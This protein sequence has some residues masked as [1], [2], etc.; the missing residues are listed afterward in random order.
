MSKIKMPRKSPSLDMTPMVDLAFLLVTFFMLT[1]QF[2]PDEPVVVDMPSSISEKILPDNVMLVTVDSANR[3]FFNLDGKDTRRNMLTKMGE[4]YAVKFTDDEL[5]RFSIMS[6]FGM[7][8]QQ[9][10][11][12]ISLGEQER[13]AFMKK[14]QGIPID[15]INNQLGQWIY[16]GRFAEAEKHSGTKVEKDKQ[17]RFAIKGDGNSTYTTVKRVIEIF[18]ENNVNRFNL[19]TNLEQNPNKAS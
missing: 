6:T 18:Q 10:K 13:K 14:S 9:L 16:Y 7:T 3:V 12:Y 17:L 19:I 4:K 1:T 15:S 8:V 5:N 2:R 11:Q